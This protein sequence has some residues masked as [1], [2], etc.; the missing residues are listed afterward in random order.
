M[1]YSYLTNN[2]NLR[3]SKIYNAS[4]VPTLAA[5]SKE[6]YLITPIIYGFILSAQPGPFLSSTIKTT[7]ESTTIP[8]TPRTPPANS[9]STS[10]HN[11]LHTAKSVTQP[12]AINSKYSFPLFSACI[13]PA[14]NIIIALAPNQ[15]VLSV[16]SNPCVSK[17]QIPTYHPIAKNTLKN[18]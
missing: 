14:K 7:A 8:N 12:T 2:I 9:G 17:V 13:T 1:P 4:S 3:S 11:P 15:S 16:T 5:F 18:G 10:H 6:S